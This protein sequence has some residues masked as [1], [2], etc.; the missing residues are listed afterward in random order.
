M[1]SRAEKYKTYQ[2]EVVFNF[3]LRRLFTPPCPEEKNTNFVFYR[4][5]AIFSP[6]LIVQSSAKRPGCHDSYSGK[7]EKSVQPG[8]CK[9]VPCT[10]LQ[11]PGATLPQRRED[12]DSSL[13]HKSTLVGGSCNS[14]SYF[15]AIYLKSKQ[16][17]QTALRE[18][19]NMVLA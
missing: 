11:S 10:L 15:L 18:W 17:N 9:R 2:R 8:D 19:R 4:I 13:L 6:L 14:P 16:N 7:G 12:E 5:S 3:L 1:H